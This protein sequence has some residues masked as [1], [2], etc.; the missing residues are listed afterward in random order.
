M[1]PCLYAPNMGH[2]FGAIIQHDCRT[3]PSTRRMCYENKSYSFEI[4]S[5]RTWRVNVGIR[6]SSALISI[7][8]LTAVRSVGNEANKTFR[9]VEQHMGAG[10]V[11]TQNPD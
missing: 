4:P 2:I 1:D 11:D 5:I 7:V 8:V 10:N 6:T 3:A 9:T